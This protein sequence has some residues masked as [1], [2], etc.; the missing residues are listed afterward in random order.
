MNFSDDSLHAAATKEKEITE[1]F[2]NTKISTRAKKDQDK[3]PQLW[4]SEDRRVHARLIEIRDAVHT[5]LCNN[6]DFP[7]GMQHISELITEV[8]KYR[9]DPEYKNVILNQ[10]SRYVEDM[11]R[12]FGVIQDIDSG[13]SEGNNA[14]SGASDRKVESLLDAISSFRDGIRDAARNKK[15]P[16]EILALCDNFRDEA[17]IDLGVRLED[18]AC[19]SC[20]SSGVSSSSVS[21]SS[22]GPAQVSWKS[23]WKLDDPVKLIRER[24]EKKLV[25]FTTRLTKAT[26]KLDK[27]CK[28]VEKLKDS[29][30]SASD[31]FASQK[32]KYS[33]FSADGKPTRD[34]EGKELAKSAGKS[35]QK[36]FDRRD[37]AHKD[38][39]SKNMKNPNLLSDL[40]DEEH[41]LIAEIAKLKEQIKA[42]S[43]AQPQL[44]VQ[45]QQSVHDG[46]IFSL[47]SEE[48]QSQMQQKTATDSMKQDVTEVA[49][50]WHKFKGLVLSRDDE[51]IR[52][53]FFVLSEQTSPSKITAQ[54]MHKLVSRLHHE[55]L[56]RT[57][58]AGEI[59]DQGMMF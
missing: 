44:T 54:D 8:N 23:V 38:Y 42:Q 51:D 56:E 46:A 34:S 30:V 3:F 39:L 28:D 13:L 1:F 35:I 11:M 58:S 37:K 21:S 49:V 48:A 17:M 20:A 29:S 12:A 19:S 7:K 41:A 2:Q 6:F 22:S 53:A 18:V 24:E 15:S 4:N 10:V 59:N 26:N 5:A 55:R 33:L 57:L 27:I 25:E 36:T 50:T 43:Q 14:S 52:H 9:L 31:Y 16:Q 40:V 32:D 47:D 45:P